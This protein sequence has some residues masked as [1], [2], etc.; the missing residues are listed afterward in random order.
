MIITK[1]KNLFVARHAGQT[2]IA[3]TRRLAR[4][5]LESII[6]GKK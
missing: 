1:R 4:E 2:V 6:W 3:N 5:T